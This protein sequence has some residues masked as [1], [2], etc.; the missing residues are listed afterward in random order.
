MNILGPRALRASLFAT[1]VLAACS[2]DRASPVSPPDAESP[3]PSIAPL[4]SAS[5]APSASATAPPAKP[6]P[7]FNVVLVP[8]DSL[9]ADMPWAGY[10]RDIAP[11]L[12]ALSKRAV[13]YSQAHSISSFT[14]KSL[15]AMLASKYP[16]EMP[17]DG[18][19]F[20]K[21]APSNVTLCD[22]LAGEQV[23][24]VAAMA[25][26]YLAK[27]YAGID[28]SFKS[29]SLVQGISFDYN[30]DPFVTSHKLTPLAIE[31]LKDPTLH[32]GSRF[33]A[34]FHFM[35]PHDEYQSHPESPHW[36][37]SLKDLYD[38]EV[39]YTDIWVGKLLDFIEEQPW[40]TRTVIIVTADP[41][42]SFGEH[43]KWKHAQE[44]YETHVHVPLM[45]LVPGQPPRT[46]DAARSHIDLAPTILALMGAKAAP[47]MN[48]S[49][50]LDEILGGEA[51]PRD[52]ISDLPPDEYNDK[53]RSIIH[54]GWKLIVYGFDEKY[55]LYKL[56]DDP[57]E[58]KDLYAK[59]REVAADMTR[60]FKEASKAIK[61]V[62]P[63][64]GIPKH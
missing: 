26:A 34:W 17:R 46:I 9:R 13:V 2:R 27:G 38:E 1:L 64:G 47:S 58:L 19:F 54:D 63:T 51:S 20:T 45:F 15:P 5:S 59:E 61:D 55:A 4:A 40:A 6:T 42:E 23:P 56:A 28:H 14:S 39:F 53:R 50:I 31:T 36:G 16:S 44:L 8:I 62:A 57:M 43:Y 24:C 48:G 37:K 25:H 12:T 33:F 29:W 52:V 3:A 35:D 30:T 60:R 18:L 41:G 11:R 7:P 32:A 10:A 49:S 22:V 21:Y